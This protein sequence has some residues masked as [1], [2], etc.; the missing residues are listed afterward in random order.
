[1][2]TLNI[3]GIRGMDWKAIESEVERGGR[4]VVYTTVV[5]VVVMTFR[6]PSSITFVR[7][8]DSRL[9]RGL[10][11]T[12]VTLIAG[13]WGFPWG[14]VYTPIALVTN[15]AGGKDVTS[16]VMAELEMREERRLNAKAR[17]AAARSAPTDA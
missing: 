8:G 16:A 9:A 17:T 11:Q 12:L 6:T 7:G 4:F 13:W 14:F 2:A 10:T 1:M 5:S 15:L 3:D